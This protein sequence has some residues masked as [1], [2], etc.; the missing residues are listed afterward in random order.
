[1]DFFGD[2]IHRVNFFTSTNRKK[3]QKMKERKLWNE[4]N[5]RENKFIIIISKRFVSS[6]CQYERVSCFPKISKCSLRIHLIG[7]C[8]RLYYERK[9]VDGGRERGDRT[10]RL[11]QHI[12]LIYGSIWHCFPL[13]LMFFVQ[14]CDNIIYKY[15]AALT[16]S[17]SLTCKTSQTGQE[18]YNKLR[19]STPKLMYPLY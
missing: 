7:V 16:H 11:F 19:R 14:R 4:V 5:G 9:N 3:Q 13:I 15:T 1:M 17:L 8:V 12:Q 2:L 6:L 18:E 10:R